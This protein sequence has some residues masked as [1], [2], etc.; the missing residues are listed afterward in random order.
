[1]KKK[2]GNKNV[3]DKFVLVTNVTHE[4]TLSNAFCQHKAST[5][6]RSRQLGN[7]FFNF[8]KNMQ[9]LSELNASVP[10]TKA[11]NLIYSKTLYTNMHVQTQGFGI[12][13]TGP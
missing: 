3:F 8:L 2:K 4:T 7:S 6:K 13:R 9:H 1:M 5:T 12:V 10:Q 11:K